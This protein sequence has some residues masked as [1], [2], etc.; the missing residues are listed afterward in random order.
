VFLLILLR[1]DGADAQRFD[2]IGQH[3]RRE[4]PYALGRRVRAALGRERKPAMSRRFLREL[5]L[6]DSVLIDSGVLTP[7]N[8]FAVYRRPEVSAATG[9]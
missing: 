8:A 1:M 7:G 6:L 3:M 9:D 4:K 5:L 2:N